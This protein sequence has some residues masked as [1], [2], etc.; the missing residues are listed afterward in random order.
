MSYCFL[1]YETL[2][3]YRPHTVFVDTKPYTIACR[4]ETAC[5]VCRVMSA[6]VN[7]K[8]VEAMIKKLFGKEGE[9]NG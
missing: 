3:L 9:T 5:K 7:W 2:Q 4:G 6:T 8:D 1:P